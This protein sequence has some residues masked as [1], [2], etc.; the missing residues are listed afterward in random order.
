MTPEK[1]AANTDKCSVCDG[2]VLI[3]PAL[4]FYVSALINTVAADDAAEA[5]E[6]VARELRGFCS[7]DCVAMAEWEKANKLKLVKP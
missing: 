5:L 1:H 3:R 4:A 7:S 6:F 2:R